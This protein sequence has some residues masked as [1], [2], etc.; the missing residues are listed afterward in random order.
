MQRFGAP[1]KS[2]Q[3]YIDRAGAYAVLPRG[4]QML[5]TYQAHPFFELQLPGGGID[6]GESPLQAL[7]RE[8]YEETGW[9]IRVI[10]KLSLYQRYTFMPEYDIWARKICHI[11]LA[12]PVLCKGAPTEATHRAVWMD[13]KH[14]AHELA[15]E[16]DRHFAMWTTR[17]T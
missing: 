14:A 13:G 5:L 8:V 2:T 15:S 9:S 6:H 7:H 4:R 3:K 10:R 11:Y 17:N 12:T 16:A 1:A